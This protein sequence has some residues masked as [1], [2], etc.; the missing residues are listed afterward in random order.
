MPT[1]AKIADHETGLCYEI[2]FAK[3]LGFKESKSITRL[4][5]MF[6]NVCQKFYYPRKFFTI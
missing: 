1:Y 6:D 4:F 3:K 2:D 5:N